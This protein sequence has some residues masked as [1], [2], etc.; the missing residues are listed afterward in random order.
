LLLLTEVEEVAIDRVFASGASDCFVKPIVDTAFLRQVQQ[1]LELPQF[2]PGISQPSHVIYRQLQK[3]TQELRKTEAALRQI[4]QQER[5]LNQTK[6]Q[7]LSTVSHEL[8]TPL[9]SIL[10]N[11][12][13]LEYLIQA[14]T[15]ACCGGEYLDHIHTAIDQILQVLERSNAIANINAETV[16]LDPMIVDLAE[17]CE[18]IATGWQAQNEATHQITFCCNEAVPVLAYVDLGLMQQMLKQLLS[19]AV[20]FS[21]T[22]GA[23]RVHL[24]STIAGSDLYNPKS[25]AILQVEDQ[26]VGISETDQA[27]LFRQF[28][29]GGNANQIPGT[30]GLGLGL[31]IVK[32]IVDLHSGKITFHSRPGAGTTFTVSLPLQASAL[33]LSTK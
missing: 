14:D 24:Y 19:N 16:E 5:E 11:T 33:L 20:R 12:E 22:G 2:Q 30:P 32:Q 1:I 17:V 23:I 9:T 26:G 18:A 28:Y 25:V 15:N 7:F 29:R 3:R 10:A 4:R 21:P 6:T 13:F 31:A 8:R 27:H